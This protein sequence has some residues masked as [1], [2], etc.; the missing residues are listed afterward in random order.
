MAA[1]AG[2]LKLGHF[3][4]ATNLYSLKIKD[5][6]SQGNKKTLVDMENC[7]NEVKGYIEESSNLMHARLKVPLGNCIVKCTMRLTYLRIFA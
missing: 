4:S 1:N 3:I 7:E 2:D 5:A 6:F